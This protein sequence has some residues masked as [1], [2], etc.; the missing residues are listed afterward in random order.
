MVV[1]SNKTRG[2]KNFQERQEKEVNAKNNQ[3]QGYNRYQ[4][5][6]NTDCFGWKYLYFLLF[7]SL[8][9]KYLKQ[10]M[11]L[12]SHCV[13][14]VLV[15]TLV[16]WYKMSKLMGKCEYWSSTNWGNRSCTVK[17]Q[18][19]CRICFQ[20]RCSPE[21]RDYHG[22]WCEQWVSMFLFFREGRNKNLISN[23]GL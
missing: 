3:N 5:D 2:T 15:V 21:T 10:I 13:A 23:P 9:V 12:S 11:W 1:V 4:N 7:E 22:E 16:F 19:W 20:C 17:Y 14:A 18:N 6:M 8:F